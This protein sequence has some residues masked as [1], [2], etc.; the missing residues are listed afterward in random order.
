MR[1]YSDWYHDLFERPTSIVCWFMP[2]R[3]VHATQ[4]V[5]R[6]SMLCHYSS[7]GTSGY[8]NIGYRIVTLA[9]RYSGV[10][11]TMITLTSD[12]Q[13]Y[14]GIVQNWPEGAGDCNILPGVVKFSRLPFCSFTLFIF[15]IIYFSCVLFVHSIFSC[16][17][18][19][20]FSSHLFHYHFGDACVGYYS[21]E[22]DP[23]SPRP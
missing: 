1:R 3:S 13:M 2:I 8:S 19:F 18:M 9:T 7:L 14:D 21:A 16:M 11:K 17:H 5:A 6:A 20:W 22:H 12:N 15:L 4:S 10:A 23:S